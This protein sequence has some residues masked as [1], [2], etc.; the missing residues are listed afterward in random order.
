METESPLRFLDIDCSLYLYETYYPSA[1]QRRI[2]RLVM[3]ELN[4]RVN[5]HITNRFVGQFQQHGHVDVPNSN[6]I[7]RWIRRAERGRRTKVKTWFWKGISAEGQRVPESFII[8]D[9]GHGDGISQFGRWKAKSY[10]PH[11]DDYY[12]SHRFLQSIIHPE[13]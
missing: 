3:R 13:I 11:I 10:P 5:Q 4:M 6:S 2:Y 1:N 7:R 9:I 8:D 12:D